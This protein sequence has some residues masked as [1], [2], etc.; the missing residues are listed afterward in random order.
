MR[1][2]ARKMNSMVIYSTDQGQTWTEP[3]EMQGALTGDR[4][5]AR[6]LKGR[7]P[8]HQLP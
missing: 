5:C 7:T 3:V 6:Y 4:H 1:E 8:L 2:N